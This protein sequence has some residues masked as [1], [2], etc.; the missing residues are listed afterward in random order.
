MTTFRLLAATALTF[1]ALPL[2]AQPTA[3]FDPARLHLFDAATQAN[4]LPA[5]GLVA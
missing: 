3:T 1:A 2:F 5:P 4:V